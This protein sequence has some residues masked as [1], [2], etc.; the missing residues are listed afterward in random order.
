MGTAQGLFCVA[1]S[2]PRNA[3]SRSMDRALAAPWSA[4]APGVARIVLVPVQDRRAVD[5]R[6]RP[7]HARRHG[8]D[9][10]QAGQH[11]DRG[12]AVYDL[13]SA[14]AASAVVRAASRSHSRVEDTRSCMAS[15][16]ARLACGT[17]NGSC[18]TKAWSCMGPR[19]AAQARNGVAN[20]QARRPSALARATAS[21]PRRCR[22][23]ARLS[24]HDGKP[25][26]LSAS[27]RAVL[28]FQVTSATPAQVTAMP[29]IESVVGT[30]SNSAHS[31]STATTGVR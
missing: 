20:G 10:G 14:T 4:G 22:S 9:R 7:A 29:I 3:R 17:S 12:A 16:A 28:R 2:P 15:P 11:H 23:T 5:D 30:I 8:N 24:A 19:N 6:R 13:P 27:T 21:A 26:Q 1:R 25:V 18:V 31:S